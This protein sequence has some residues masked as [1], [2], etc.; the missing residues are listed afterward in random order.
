MTADEIVRRLAAS[1]WVYDHVA[2]FHCGAQVAYDAESNVTGAKEQ[3]TEGCVYA[4]A[5][6]YVE[7]IPEPGGPDAEGFAPGWCCPKDYCC[8]MYVGDKP[9][10]EGW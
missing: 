5:L 7:T 10:P 3:H 9:C 6:A 4:L 8:V 2:C 1:D